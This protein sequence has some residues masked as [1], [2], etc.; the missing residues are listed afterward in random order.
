MTQ[1]M[2]TNVLQKS[3]S[4]SY[5]ICYYVAGLKFVHQDIIKFCITIVKVLD[6][7]P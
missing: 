3:L 4:H 7:E 2:D 1:T 6:I 5:L